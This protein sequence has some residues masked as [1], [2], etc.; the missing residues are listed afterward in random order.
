MIN[1]AK[2]F[3]SDGLQNH[4]EFAPINKYINKCYPWTSKRMSKESVKSPS[5]RDN[6]FA[7]KR[8]ASYP[9]SITKL[10]GNYLKQNTVS[11]LH[12]NVVNLYVTYELDT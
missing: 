6:S 8:N 2:Y 11:F 7:P 5:T 10:N 3:S 9:L 4:L 12:K 1:G